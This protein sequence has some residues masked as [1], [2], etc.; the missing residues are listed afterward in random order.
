MGLL[1][2]DGHACSTSKR[3]AL[4]NGN[5]VKKT[6]LFVNSRHRELNDTNKVTVNDYEWVPEMPLRHVKNIQVEYA[7]IPT[8]FTNV[9]V[10]EN[11]F[12][13]TIVMTFSK[14]AASYRVTKA[15]LTDDGIRRIRKPLAAK[16]RCR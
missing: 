5:H 12:K 16:E 11:S 6:K 10:G 1:P 15:S 9:V 7:E 3:Q 4:G 13:I 8:S 2:E 14:V